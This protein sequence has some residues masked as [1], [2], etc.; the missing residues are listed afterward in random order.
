MLTL[1]TVPTEAS[2]DPMGLFL[3]CHARIRRFCRLAVKLGTETAPPEEVKQAAHAVHRY[4]A[5]ALPLHIEDEDLSLSPRL[6]AVG[7]PEVKAALERMSDEHDPLEASIRALLPRWRTLMDH[8][9]E[10]DAMK[11][12][13]LADAEVLEREMLAHLVHEEEVIFPAARKLLDKADFDGLAQQ[14][15]DRRSPSA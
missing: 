8:P 11:S 12:G 2:N 9:E 5:K 13:L 4:F 6:E 3:E 1:R 15:R 14:M 7:T 10:L